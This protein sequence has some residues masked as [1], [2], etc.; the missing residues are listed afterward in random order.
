MSHG[1]RFGS[2]AQR[3]LLSRNGAFL[4]TSIGRTQ[5]RRFA[6][7]GASVPGIVLPARVSACDD[8]HGGRKL[9][10]RLSD[11]LLLF[12]MGMKGNFRLD[13]SASCYSPQETAC[14]RRGRSS[15]TKPGGASSR[16]PCHPGG[17][18]ERGSFPTL[19]YG[20]RQQGVIR[21][22]PLMS[23]PVCDMAL[24]R[25]SRKVVPRS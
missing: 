17:N 10:R 22:G 14:A 23:R 24:G 2:L 9:R 11:Y 16:A 3:T 20:R 13:L 25:W 18:I 12:I 7:A 19:G 1:Y 6:T 8:A 21:Y 4:D 15:T 5:V